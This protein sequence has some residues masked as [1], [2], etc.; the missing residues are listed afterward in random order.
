M[1]YEFNPENKLFEF[2]N[3]YKVQNLA[4]LVAGGLLTI[5]GI[6]TLVSVR[7][8]IAQGTDLAALKV[9]GIAVVLMVLGFA[10]LGRAFVQLRFSSAATAQPVWRR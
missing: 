6:G 1:S 5:G 9:I 2:P 3:P 8:R 7:E 4:L 10:F